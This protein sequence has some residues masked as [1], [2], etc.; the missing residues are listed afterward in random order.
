MNDIP[1]IY[2][3]PALALLSF[4][5]GMIWKAMQDRAVEAVRHMT[6]KPGD[7]SADEV[8]E[9]VRQNKPSEAHS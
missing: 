4:I 9:Y 1:W 5:V 8:Q 6:V 7:L 2:V 3:L